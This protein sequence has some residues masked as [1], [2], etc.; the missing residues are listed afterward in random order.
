MMKKIKF[1]AYA[2]AIALLS[3]SVAACSSSDDIID[4]PDYNPANNTVKTQFTI[5]FPNASGKTTRMAAA[6]VQAANDGSDFLGIKNIKLISYKALADNIE[7]VSGTL[8]SNVP[9]IAN[10]IT[11]RTSASA[12]IPDG[13]ISNNN[14]KLYNDIEIGVGT[15]SFLLY[16]E[17][18]VERSSVAQKFQS[19]A[20]VTPDDWTA[21]PE[22]FVFGPEAIYDGTTNAVATK[23]A[24]YLTNIASATGW[25]AEGSTTFLGK[26]YA[27]FVTLRAGSS[28]SVQAAVQ[29]LYFSLYS[30]T[31][32]VSTAIKTAITATGYAT[33]DSDGTLQ[34]DASLDG[35]PENINLPDGAAAI[36]WS[37]STAS[38]A[39]T[40][41]GI[42]GTT[43]ASTAF[44]A[45]A[46]TNYVYPAALYY[47]TKSNIKTAEVFKNPYYLSSKDWASILNEYPDANTEVTVNTHSVALVTPVEYAVGRLDIKVQ[48]ADGSLYDRTGAAVALPTAGLDFTGVLIGGQS[49]VDYEFAPTAGSTLYTMYDKVASG[50]KVTTTA[51]TSVQNHTLVFQTPE[52]GDNQKVN[53]ALEFVNNTG[54]DFNGVDG[55]IPADC[56]FYLIAQLDPTKSETGYSVTDATKTGYRVFMQDY[57]TTV[58]LTIGQGTQSDGNSVGLGS[59]YNVIPD[60]R[61]PALELGL[62]VNL[63]WQPGINFTIN[64]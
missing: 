6:D 49:Q 54:L 62:S 53:I 59:A 7:S 10:S 23:L 16:G 45:I 13:L 2:G 55:V 57:I 63:E 15:K 31:D 35:Y 29:D 21:I 27:K 22:N 34:F 39:G 9:A 36:S 20:I 12:A 18:N 1:F 60:L 28:A 5:S 11:D 42:G 43:N 40:A 33:A 56:K 32:A 51:P 38:V 4:N 19:G 25:S 44:S 17:S 48:A 47:R 64:I 26:L 3:A 50:T 41:S 52:S 37:G 61:N 30:K 14:A 46:L 8:I 24:T 58:N